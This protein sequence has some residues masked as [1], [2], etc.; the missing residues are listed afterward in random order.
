MRKISRQMVYKIF[1]SLIIFCMIMIIGNVK[2]G[3]H[4]DEIYTFGLSNHQYN[5]SILPDILEEQ[6]YSGKQL[7]NEY[8]TVSGE[9]RFDYENVF[10]N[11]END[12]HPPLYYLLVHTICSF[13]PET[14]SKWM[15]LFLN[16]VL[17][18]IVLW[19]IIWL[20]NYFVDDKK[21]SLF[22]GI[23]FTL[24]M[25][26][27]NNILFFRMYVLLAV[28]INALIIFF[29]KFS[30]ADNR[31]IQYP[32]L[33]II[34]LLGIL[35]QYYFG[36][37]CFFACFV[38]ALFLIHERNWKKF[39]LC[40]LTICVD[41]ICSL[42][43]FPA[44]INHIFFGYRGVDSIDIS[45]NVSLME[46][47]KKYYLIFNRELFGGFFIVLIIFTFVLILYT[48]K[49]NKKLNVFKEKNKNYLQIII[50]TLLY[51][52]VIILITPYQTDRYVFSIMGLL[53]VCIFAP[54]ILL[55]KKYSPRFIWIVGCL[56]ILMVACSYRFGI[57]N[58]YL[59]EIDKKEMLENK[60]AIPCVYIFD[61]NNSWKV[62]YNYYDL[63]E[64]DNIFF[65][66]SDHLE[67]LNNEKYKKYDE[68]IVYISATLDSDN[69][70]STIIN[71]NDQ[72]DNTETLFPVSNVVTYYLE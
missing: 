53:H 42:M 7:W 39:G 35:T 11:Q 69:I 10:V 71:N 60:E 61:S 40:F 27:I 55:L 33:G 36:I 1:I 13:F 19:Q 65:L 12:V 24:C 43:I 15:G 58:A 56:A 38:Y 70:V 2:S 59:G 44:M 34:V 22:F 49:K 47:F 20:F 72:L 29:C 64:L 63:R 4:V 62:L 18:V 25:G 54:I 45:G 3:F 57:P 52:L 67:K 16:A 26:S 51:I 9:H 17:A 8:T 30:P 46:K 37:F 31:R 5:G 14:F 21:I 6:N 50:P 32:I 28:M 23:L 66:S 41:A 48:A 68:L